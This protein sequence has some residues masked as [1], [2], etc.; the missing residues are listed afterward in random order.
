[1]DGM[2]GVDYY[3]LGAAGQEDKVGYYEIRD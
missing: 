1:M 3:S 2:Y